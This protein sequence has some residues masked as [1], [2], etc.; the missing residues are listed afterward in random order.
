MTLHFED[1]TIDIHRQKMPFRVSESDHYILPL[2]SITAI[3]YKVSSKKISIEVTSSSK[4][5]AHIAKKDHRQFDQ[6]PAD[7]LFFTLEAA[8]P[9]GKI[10]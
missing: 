8:G 1:D 3:L 2:L 9:R 6:Y 5:K 4:S 10:S 7:F